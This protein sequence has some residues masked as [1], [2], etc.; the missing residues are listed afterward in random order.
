[1]STMKRY[2]VAQEYG[3]NHLVP[4]LDPRPSAKIERADWMLWRG[5]A[6]PRKQVAQTPSH[7]AGGTVTVLRLKRRKH[8]SAT[9]Q[10]Q[11]FES[12]PIVLRYAESRSLLCVLNSVDV[13]FEG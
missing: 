2:Y 11:S 3:C 6:Q 10:F 1:M 7:C 4:S 13:T 12:H 5:N 8:H 9:S